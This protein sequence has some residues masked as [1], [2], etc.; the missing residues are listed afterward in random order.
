M[1]GNKTRARA[2]SS[3]VWALGACKGMMQ[4]RGGRGPAQSDDPPLPDT[5]GAQQLDTSLHAVPSM[6]PSTTAYATGLV[7]KSRQVALAHRVK[8][9]MHFTPRS[10]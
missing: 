5:P 3:L 9:S 8:A 4:S 7:F 6:C 1:R 2:L 10:S